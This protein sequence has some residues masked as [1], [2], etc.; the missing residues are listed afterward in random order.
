MENEIKKVWNAAEIY[1]KHELGEI[2][3]GDSA[4]DKNVPDLE[5]YLNMSIFEDIKK[6]VI[7]I[8]DNETIKT[9]VVSLDEIKDIIKIYDNLFQNLSEIKNLSSVDIHNIY[10]NKNKNIKVLTIDSSK[11]YITILL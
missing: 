9:K 11:L 5:A 4:Y 1:V 8:K 2:C 6:Y 7:I 3:E 10:I